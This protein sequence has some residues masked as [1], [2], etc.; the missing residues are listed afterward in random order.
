MSYPMTDAISGRPAS[1]APAIQTTARTNHRNALRAKCAIIV[2]VGQEPPEYSHL[3]V[4]G[5]ALRRTL[6][7]PGEMVDVYRSRRRP[8][9]IPQSPYY[10]VIEQPTRELPVSAAEIQE[11]YRLSQHQERLAR[12][13]E[14]ESPEWIVRRE[15]GDLATLGWWDSPYSLTRD[16]AAA[17]GT[18]SLTTAE[19]YCGVRP[20]LKRP[21]GEGERS[22]AEPVAPLSEVGRWEAYRGLGRY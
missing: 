22:K 5:H 1:A 14:I 2:P 17:R 7:E 20:S 3:F 11:L 4:S 16:D 18:E 9:D 15:R 12:L 21:P 6:L 8:A 10:R 19:L 13:L